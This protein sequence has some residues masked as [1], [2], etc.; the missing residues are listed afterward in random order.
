MERT[1]WT[2]QGKIIPKP[3]RRAIEGISKECKGTEIKQKNYNL[4]TTLSKG[5]G[6]QT[7][8]VY[9]FIIY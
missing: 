8:C 1:S 9:S 2:K 7:A 4:T 5:E 6:D 3:Y